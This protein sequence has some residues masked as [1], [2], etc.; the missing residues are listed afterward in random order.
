[1]N[2]MGDQDMGAQDGEAPPQHHAESAQGNQ[3]S[4]EPQPAQQNHPATPQPFLMAEFQTA[5][6]QFYRLTMEQFKQI[7][8]RVA[9]QQEIQTAMGQRIAQLQ[10]GQP[11][12]QTQ[13]QAQ[14]MNN[15]AHAPLP[16]QQQQQ[17]FPFARASSQEVPWTQA[18]STQPA[19]TPS[20]TPHPSGFGYLP[21]MHSNPRPPQY[22]P[23]PPFV[24]DP[25]SLNAVERAVKAEQWITE[26][27]TWLLEME[28]GFAWTDVQRISRHV[29]YT[30]G[31]FATW[32]R[33][34]TA[35]IMSKAQGV[36]HPGAPK[37]IE[38]MWA[39]MK[40]M[41]VD[42]DVEE[43]RQ[44]SF[45][46]FKQGNKTAREYYTQWLTK[47]NSLARTPA[48]LDWAFFGGLNEPTQLRLKELGYSPESKTY[49]E[50]ATQAM[51]SDRPS[52][53]LRHK[54]AAIPGAEETDNGDG[55]GSDHTDPGSEDDLAA[56]PHR[57]GKGARRGQSSGPR[58]SRGGRPSRN[59]NTG[60]IKA[61]KNPTDKDGKIMTCHN[62]HS[63]LHL[64]RDCPHEALDQEN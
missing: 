23:K 27:K 1:M 50:L 56:L 10:Q 13:A 7:G 4:Q 18:T 45:R 34:K 28:Q 15:P 64:R 2:S 40:S 60:K 36:A 22:K 38:D 52:S 8:E 59:Q 3:P 17:S 62:C 19:R 49:Q 11:Q 43:Q 30:G 25:D 24:F 63:I 16:T 14:A 57:N 54:F 53:Q 21:Q 29:G 31:S 44:S 58:N 33:G 5:M 51:I 47:L 12:P 42:K 9:A 35:A 39:E 6:D 26:S 32:W 37:G 41:Y 20:V 46:T 48:E 55:D 61:K